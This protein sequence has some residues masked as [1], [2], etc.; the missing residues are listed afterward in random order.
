[1]IIG[2]HHAT[3]AIPHRT[4]LAL[5][6]P[7][8]YRHCL[9]TWQIANYDNRSADTSKV[10]NSLG[11][12]RNYP[13]LVG[14]HLTQPVPNP[15]FDEP[16]ILHYPP[17]LPHGHPNIRPDRAAPSEPAKTRP[18]IG[19]GI[20]L[21]RRHTWMT[22]GFGMTSHP[23]TNGKCARKRRR[24]A[25]ENGFVNMLMSCLEKERGCLPCAAAGD[26]DGEPRCYGNLL[27]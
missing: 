14:P 3:A 16:L 12:Q 15:P 17:P 24:N 25:R 11:N 9:F 10:H 22:R 5:A 2:L 26:Q 21:S 6:S 8:T 27:T 18:Q 7:S 23:A 13:V 1:M 20:S 19:R 4:A